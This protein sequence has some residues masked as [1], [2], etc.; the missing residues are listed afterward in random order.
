MSLVNQGL[1]IACLVGAVAGCASREAEDPSKR[2]FPVDVFVTSDPGR[3][4]PGVELVVGGRPLAKTDSAGRAQVALRGVE[5]DAVELA[6]KCPEGFRSP[7][8]PILVSLRSLSTGSRAPMFDAHCAPLT[9]T[10]VIGIRAENGPNLPVTYLG[11]EVGR[12]DAW[13]AAHVFLTVKPNEQV[14]IALD[15]KSESPKRSKLRPESP[16]LTFVAKDKDDFVTLEQKFEVERTGARAH[17]PGPTPPKGPK[18]I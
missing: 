16:T 2:A 15:T 1:V 7:S 5:G 11:T 14:T 3:G 17:A 8:E 13:G 6:V 18:R 9:R 12:T 4:T 10:V